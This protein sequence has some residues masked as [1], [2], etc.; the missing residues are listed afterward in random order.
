MRNSLIIRRYAHSQLLISSFRFSSFKLIDHGIA[1]PERTG[2]TGKCSAVIFTVHTVR[3][4][5]SRNTSPV[6]NSSSILWRV[7]LVVNH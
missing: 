3:I 4:A 6:G 1:E 5:V 7:W 2:T